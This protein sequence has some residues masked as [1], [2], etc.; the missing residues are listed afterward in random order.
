MNQ[1]PFE[2]T[3]HQIFRNYP[4][5]QMDQPPFEE[6]YHQIFRDYPHLHKYP[7]MGAKMRCARTISYLQQH[8]SVGSTVL[9]VGAWPGILALLM[10]RMGWR[11]IA[12]DKNTERATTSWPHSPPNDKSLEVSNILSFKEI[13][14]REQIESRSLNVEDT[15]LPF[16]TESFGAVVFTEV[17]EHLW[18]DPIFALAEINRVLQYDGILIL[19]TPNF[20][21]LQHR[22][23][24][25]FGY[26][27]RVIEHPFVAFLKHRQ[28]GHL[29]H[30]RLY[31][32][33]ELATTLSLLGFSPHFHY[34]YL[35]DS[36][37]PHNAPSTPGVAHRDT[38]RLLP[39][40]RLVR[41]FIRSP[42]S[43]YYA[44]G[45][46]IIEILERRIPTLR[47]HI[48]VVATK[49]TNA[50]FYQNYPKEIERLLG[51][52]TSSDMEG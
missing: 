4:H 43:Y 49:T 10:Q 6:T 14:E 7:C 29:G 39:I 47:P 41:K 40:S 38:R 11:V 5:L 42:K 19:S 51:K 45:A 21:S 26:V 48:F 30:L 24:F 36:Q 13:C 35:M 46:T 33:S 20:L 22:L 32:P 34:G 27:D 3:Y 18:Y 23:N 37:A 50:D 2:E 16:A 15:V 8:V 1:P 12:V 9:D 52:M 44:A 31:S 25:V 17:I 28:M